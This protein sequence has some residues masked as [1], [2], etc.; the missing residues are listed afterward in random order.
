VTHDPERSAWSNSSAQRPRIAVAVAGAAFGVL[1]TATAGCAATPAG[2]DLTA[3][4]AQVAEAGSQ[5]MPFD[6]D[7]T[8]H[9]FAELPDGGRQTVTA[10]TPGDVEQIALIRQHLQDEAE[11][12]RRADFGDPATIH[13]D[14]MPGLAELR[15]SAGRIDVTYNELED[16]AQ[17]T[18][19]TSEPALT[20][21]LHDW[22]AAQISDHG[23]H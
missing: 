5:V 4:Q 9:V 15:A 18:Y 13:G 11:K 16:G 3:R 23:G 6:L 20:T 19:R 12:F 14:D 1:L 10:D 2:D 22:F 7:R 21:A 8:T 17:L